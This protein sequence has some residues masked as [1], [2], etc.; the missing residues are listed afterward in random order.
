[1]FN[2]DRVAIVGAS[3]EDGS[4]GRAL[5][6]NLSSFDG[7]VI[8]GNP[9]LETVLGSRRSATFPTPHRSTW[10]SSLFP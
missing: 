8:P 1:V 3:D 4:V 10:P 2:P 7:D 6:E 5:L 9:D